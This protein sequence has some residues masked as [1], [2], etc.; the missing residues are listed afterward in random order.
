MRLLATISLACAC[1]CPALTL[2]QDY[3]TGPIQFVVPYTPGTTGDM[4][5]LPEVKEAMH[6]Q[7]I[8]PAGGPPG[9]FDALLRNELKM[10]SQ[11][12]TRSKIV[13]D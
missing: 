8:E 5:A 4:L 2:A 1:V 6:K 7:G 10:W 12:V 9:R 3:P 11:V 13:I